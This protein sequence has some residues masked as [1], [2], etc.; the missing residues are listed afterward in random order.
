MDAEERAARK[1]ELGFTR[2]QQVIGFVGRLT[3]EK[4]IQE[5]Y[6]AF[7]A[8]RD[9]GVQAGLL[10]I[11]PLDDRAP[12]PAALADSLSRDPNVCLR[13]Y[14]EDTWHYYP[15]MDVLALPTWRE[16]FGMCAIEAAACAVPVVATDVVGCKDAVADC[17]TGTLIPVGQPAKLS[18][19]IENYLLNA[20]LSDR[21][22]KSGRERVSHEFKSVDIWTAIAA[23]Y[24]DRLT[25][26][27]DPL[28]VLPDLTIDRG[29]GQ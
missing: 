6:E 12:I 29:M 20:E 10:L 24:N 14:V 8:L 9:R 21:H 11:G 13:G 26:T 7:T 28:T 16:G 5:L 3:P 2:E 22:G 15:L 17:E 1:Q 18:E 4:G 23:L 27:Q 25:S 19:A